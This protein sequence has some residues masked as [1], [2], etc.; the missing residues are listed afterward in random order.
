MVMGV[1]VLIGLI[2]R[3]R[4]WNRYELVAAAQAAFLVLTP[5]FGVQYTVLVVPMLC[6]LSPLLGLAYGTAAGVFIGAVYWVYRV[7]GWPIGS[8]F[9]G[10]IPESTAI[11]GL[12]AWLILIV[13]LA[14][15]LRSRPPV[16]RGSLF[17]PFPTSAR[18]NVAATA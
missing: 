17:P 5:G 14:R 9:T 3:R 7:P 16:Q 2:A 1:M 18:G 11:L 15:Q 6:A 13:Y 4:G 8:R 12:F 10:G